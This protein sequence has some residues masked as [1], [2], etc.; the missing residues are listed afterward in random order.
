MGDLSVSVKNYIDNEIRLSARDIQQCA[1]SRQW[2]LDRIK[3]EISA[4]TNQPILFQ[5][6]PFVNFG[7]YF[8]G[9]K[10][11]DVDEYDILVVIDAAGGQYSKNAIVTGTG[12]GR[13]CPN[14]I[15]NQAFYKADGSGVSS[16]KLKLWLHKIVA[17]V[18]AAYGGVPPQI[19]G[20]AV[21]AHIASKDLSID[22]VPAAVISR[23]S[24]CKRFYCIPDNANADEWTATCPTDDIDRVVRISEGKENCKNVIRICKRI[25]D[26]YN[27]NI[28]SFA[29]E[30]AVCNYIE[31]KLNYTWDNYDLATIVGN[32]VDSLGNVIQTGVIT[33]LFDSSEN[34]LNR[35]SDLSGISQL[36]KSVAY[37]LNSKKATMVTTPQRDLDIYVSALFENKLS[38]F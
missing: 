17:K 13:S 16:L 23:L 19:D 5:E 26:T 31:S 20:S 11:A 18:V 28:S 3:N 6:A 32:C 22:L 38:G 30:V 29:I 7:S 4:M 14:H 9:T 33:D 12:E 10:V 24:D 27:L 2:F 1:K 25:K 15:F 37:L 36:F 34:L 21:T 8:K 35:N